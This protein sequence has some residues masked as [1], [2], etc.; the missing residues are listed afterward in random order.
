[1]T[2]DDCTFEHERPKRNERSLIYESPRGVA[3][4]SEMNRTVSPSEEDLQSQPVFKC[5]QLPCKTFL[6]TGSCPY[7]ER[8]IFLHDPYL[9]A[10]PIYI[11]AKVNFILL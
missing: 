1:M 5:R 6:S 4:L 8:C 3:S 9:A 11:K 2:V 7:S 10:K